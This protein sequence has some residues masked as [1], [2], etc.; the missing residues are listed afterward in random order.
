MRVRRDQVSPAL[1]ATEVSEVDAQ[2]GGGKK[3]TASVGGFMPK[4]RVFEGFSMSTRGHTLR[5]R[6]S[7]MGF[8]GVKNE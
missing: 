4:R 1:S 2:H 5:P 6:R 7:L 3:R 8:F